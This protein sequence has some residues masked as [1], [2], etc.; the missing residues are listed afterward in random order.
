MTLDELLHEIE[1]AP[2]DLRLLRALGGALGIELTRR[3]LDKLA[4][5]LRVLARA[6][7]GGA[8]G[9]VVGP[10]G[11]SHDAATFA[12]GYAAATIDVIAAFQA[13]LAAEADESEMAALARSAPYG[14]VLL[15]LAAGYQTSTAI[16]AQMGKNKSS[17]SRALAS[18]RE[19]GLVSA[20]AAPDGD[21]RARPHQLT[22]RGERVVEL[23]R[24]PGRRRSKGTP[25]RGSRIA[26]A[27]MSSRERSSDRLRAAP[28][29]AR[30]LR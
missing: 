9:R 28:S 16:A 5:A 15:A 13:V 11:A 21:E 2:G 7:R 26:S 20:F 6:G 14:D 25:A 10:D 8:S 24:H 29:A 30:K 22:P 4:A 17:A 18:L 12:A 27:M 1:R 19:A 3:R 23:M